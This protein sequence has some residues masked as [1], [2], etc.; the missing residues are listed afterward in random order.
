MPAF[1]ADSLK[2]YLERQ[3]TSE[4]F[5]EYFEKQGRHDLRAL[6][7]RYQDIPTFE[8]DE[9]YYFDWGAT[10]VFT[11]A[12]RGVAECSAGLFDLIGL[13]LTRL[14]ELRAGI[15]PISPHDWPDKAIYETVL[16]ASRLLLITRGV[17]AK[18][19]EDVFD[20]FR[21][22][23][24]ATKLVAAKYLPLLASAKSKDFAELRKLADDAATLAQT[25][26]ELYGAMD[27]SLHFPGET[28]H[29]QPSGSPPEESMPTRDLRGVSCPLNF[30]KTKLALSELAVGRQ[31]KIVLDDGA[32]IQ[33]VPRSVAEEGHKIIQQTRTGDHWM[34]VI[35]KR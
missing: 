25:M 8:E 1:V 32:P 24:V 22:H 17:E 30:V 23:F 20:E 13:D 21:R 10:D 14:K 26:E 5:H 12:G 28:N 6:V 18:S 16:L 11:L 2:N 31:L 15:A 4:S 9:N 7:K 33:N 27:N 19:E 35:E 29:A 3:S 34:V